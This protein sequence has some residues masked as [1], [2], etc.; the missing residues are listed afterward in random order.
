MHNDHRNVSASANV[1]GLMANANSAPHAFDIARSVLDADY[2]S[3]SVCRPKSTD[4]KKEGASLFMALKTLGGRLM[5]V[6]IN[7]NASYGYDVG[8]G[9]V[10]ERVSVFLR[11]AAASE[12]Y[13]GL[14]TAASIKSIETGKPAGAS[15]WDGYASTSIA[16]AGVRSLE[17][18]APVTVS[19]IAKP[20]LY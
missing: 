2:E 11:S 3:V 7:N 5:N 6:E 1:T 12:F 8:G 10:G 4:P 20:A 9:L 15:A 14:Q 13:A 18:G 16:E 17:S 19:P